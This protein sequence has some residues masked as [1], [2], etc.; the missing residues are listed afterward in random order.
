MTLALAETAGG[1]WG[2][3]L[4]ASLGGF[5]LAIALASYRLYRGPTLPDRVIA[6]DLIGTLCVGAVAIYAMAVGER[7]YLIVSVGLALIMFLGTV[8]FAYYIKREAEKRP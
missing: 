2:V 8:T 1:L 4:A 3:I 7:V 5:A 6:L